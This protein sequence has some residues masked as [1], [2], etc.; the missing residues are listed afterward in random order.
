MD[1]VKINSITG[2]LVNV[3]YTFDDA[4]VPS[5]TVNLNDMTISDG[6]ILAKELND[7]GQKYKA[8]CLSRIPSQA[9]AG[10][11]GME[12]GYVDGVIVPIIPETPPVTPE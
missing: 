7:Y 8:D 12:F 4:N 6:D 11:V 2:N 1:K 3:T 10:S 9:V 5:V